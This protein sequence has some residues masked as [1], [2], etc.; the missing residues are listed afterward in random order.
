MI[1]DC[2]TSLWQNTTIAVVATDLDLTV[3]QAQRMAVAA[4]DGMARAIVPSHTPLDGDLVF[5]ISTGRRQMSNPV[6]QQAELCH[7]AAV[8][9][10]RAIARAVYH[11]EPAGGD[12]LP[13][14]RQLYG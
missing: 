11:A 10:S 1:R 4:H 8:C 5:G 6:A 2:Q 7:A 3:A 14:W 12:L 9:L 13:C